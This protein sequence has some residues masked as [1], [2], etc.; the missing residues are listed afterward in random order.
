[1]GSIEFI[2]LVLLIQLNLILVY[3]LIKSK[4]N[5]DSYIK[6]SL[7]IDKITKLWNIDKFI[8]EA[9]KTLSINVS[10]PYSI[11][12]LNISKFRYVIETHGYYFG[13]KVL[14]EV[15]ELFLENLPKDS[16]S[17]RYSADR[18]VFI[19]PFDQEDDIRYQLNKLYDLL[20][21][22]KIEDK[23]I[24]LS[25]NTG[26]YIF[27]DHDYI[28]HSKDL[29]VYIDK[30]ELS[31]MEITSETK[32][33]IIFF[34]DFMH[35]M[36]LSEKNIEENL[37]NAL[38]TNEFV[39]HYQPKFDLMNS[40]VI[41]AEALVR[42]NSKRLG[43]LYPND[44][45]PF[46]E[47][48]DNI[49]EVDFYVLNQVCKL[50]RGLLDRG[51]KPIP[52]SV[53]QSRNHMLSPNYFER[54]NSILSKYNIPKHLIEF[55]ITERVFLELDNAAE[56][57]NEM[58]T[59][60]Y[61]VSMDDFGS[62][63]SSLNLLNQVSFTTL[64]LDRCFLSDKAD[65]GKSKIIL[66]SIFKMAEYLDMSVICEGVESIKQEELLKSVGCN[67]VQGYY[68]SKPIPEHE[69]VSKYIGAI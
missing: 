4:K 23:I 44:F 40:E 55:E 3:L 31:R 24:K 38:K 36:F 65:D 54:I 58:N 57:M 60:G 46:L 33:Q 13:D 21:Y 27:K 10:T 50:I 28:R 19:I 68:Y 32:N 26:V 22:V 9:Y 35:E 18:F 25:F 67:Y 16:L 69:F 62:G 53:N 41:G 39:V 59:L 12:S 64:K 61:L 17:A 51:L 1:M 43:Y 15:A 11:V 49:I 37:E 20:E 7:F 48:S 45:I 47:K 52:I 34:E 8:I 29:F 63:Y 56:F 42:W 5:H 66:K 14:K 30:A 6:E 2:I